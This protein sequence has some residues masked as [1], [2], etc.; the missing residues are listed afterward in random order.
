MTIRIVSRDGKLV[1]KAVLG[2]I[3]VD[4]TENY[5]FRC[6]LPKGTYRFTV[7]ATDSAGNRGTTAAVNTLV[8]R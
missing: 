4:S 6:W 3:R 7:A 5:I 1:Q 2:A 8:V